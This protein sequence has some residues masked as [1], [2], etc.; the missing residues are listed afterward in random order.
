M[1]GSLRSSLVLGL[2]SVLAVL[3]VAVQAGVTFTPI[4]ADRYRV[5]LEPLT[6]VVEANANDAG[7]VIIEDFFANDATDPLSEHISGQMS[8]SLN[9]GPAQLFDFVTNNGALGFRA[10][11][12]DEND[13]LFNFR[14]DYL[15]SGPGAVRV[16]DVITV[17]TVDMIF[18]N[19]SPGLTPLG[20]PYT[21]YLLENT[22]I[23][24]TAGLG[25]GIAVPAPAP[26]ALLMLGLIALG[27]RRR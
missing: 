27:V 1:T 23:I 14:P 11:A 2:L 22:Q 25:A 7:R 24:G 8:F 4:G 18:E 10:G 17:S 19:D 3:P 26:A 5:E 15:A 20:G 13:L 6:F 9:G 16:G 21:A 12:V